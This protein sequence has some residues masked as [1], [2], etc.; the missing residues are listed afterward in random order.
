MDLE[1]RIANERSGQW[2]GERL[3]WEEYDEMIR[4]KRWVLED[5]ML[6]LGLSHGE[7]EQARQE[8]AELVVEMS[9]LLVA[10]EMAYRRPG[11]G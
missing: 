1:R 10:R 2:L 7:D 4:L 5:Y 6:L 8:I 9:E 11:E 3:D